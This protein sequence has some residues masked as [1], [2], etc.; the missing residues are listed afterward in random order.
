VTPHRAATRRLFAPVVLLA[1][2]VFPSNPAAGAAPVLQPSG[3]R[4]R[5][6]GFVTCDRNQLTSFTGRVAGLERHRGR[7]VLRIETDDRTRETLT[8]RHPDGEARAFFRMAGEPFAEADWEV[9]LPSGRLRPGTRATAWV[10]A[11]EA[12]PTIDWERPQ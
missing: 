7:T 9:I 10:C 1:A 3:G 12:N 2:G 8:L 11:G 4:L 6:P 5:P